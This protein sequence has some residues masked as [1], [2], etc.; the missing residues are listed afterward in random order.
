MLNSNNSELNIEEQ[1]A[2]SGTSYNKEKLQII[3]LIRNI[4]LC[5]KYN[6]SINN[7]PR[8]CNL[9]ALQI[10]NHK[11]LIISDKTSTLK[12]SSIEKPSTIKI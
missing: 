7:Y 4:Y 3:S 2:T 1:M 5:S 6:I 8:L 12:P 10:K 11:E 9:M